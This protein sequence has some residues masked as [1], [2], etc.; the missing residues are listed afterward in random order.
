MH[1]VQNGRATNR[2]ANGDHKFDDVATVASDLRSGDHA[3]PDRYK[4]VLF[5]NEVL[6]LD[7][8]SGTVW[9]LDFERDPQSR[10]VIGPHWIEVEQPSFSGGSKRE[11]NGT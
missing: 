7:S 1:D 9:I 11:G 6:R 5:N 10:Q 8:V 3:I 4:L 2:H